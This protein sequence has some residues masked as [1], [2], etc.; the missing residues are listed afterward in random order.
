MLKLDCDIE[1]IIIRDNKAYYKGQIENNNMEISE[2]AEVP[3]QEIVEFGENRERI[4]KLFSELKKYTLDEK[5]AAIRDKRDKLLANCDWTQ[6]DDSPK[7]AMQEWL[8]Y[9]QALRDITKQADPFN[10]I[11]PVKPE[12]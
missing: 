5:W 10:I 11:W 3:E 2:I 8:D 4:P 1:D 9:R 12:D 6:I 7:K